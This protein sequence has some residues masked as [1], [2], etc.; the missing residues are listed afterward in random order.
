MD[1]RFLLMIPGPTFTEQSVLLSLARV[2]R[3]HVS[4]E[5]ED[6]L[7]E[8]LDALK[9]ILN[10]DGEVIVMPG[11]GTSAMEF[12]IAN[13]VDQGSKVLNLI[14][15]YFGEY[16]V[17]ATKA[18]GGV[19]VEV[20]CRPG[21][22]FRGKGIRELVERE[23]AK[24]LTVQHVETSTGVANYIKEIGEEIKNTETIYVVDAV[25]SLGGMEIN[26][27]EWGIDVVFTG[28]QKALAVPPGL[29]IIGLS[30]RA[31]E[32]IEE[33]KR[34]LF[35][36]DGRRW[37]AM[38]RNVRNYFSTMPVNMIYALN[39]SLKRVLSEGLENRYL[40]HKVVAEAIRGGLEALGL[41]IVA[42]KEFRSDT[43]TAVWLP[44]NVKFQDLSNE[45]MRRNVVIAGGL[46]ELTGK[47]FRIGHMGVVNPNDAISTIAAL[48]RSLSKLGYPVKLGSG[49][50]ASQQTFNKYNL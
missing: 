5:F 11:S 49:V 24:V 27:R 36:F 16:F 44:E 29:A 28:S 38:M 31:V 2:T 4:R 3:S 7:R 37:L 8:S 21:L 20:R 1:E 32:L 14:S 13:F 41:N 33:K 50:E 26:M 46:G 43:V 10:T 40:R 9:K 22:G 35:F 34:E 47:I 30:K 18:R 25:A 23:G 12:S 42:D 15:G 17:Q 39:E 19:P 45:M 6:V 48:E